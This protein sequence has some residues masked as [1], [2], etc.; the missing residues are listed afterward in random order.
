MKKYFIVLAVAALA[1]SAACTKV[2]TITPDQKISFEVANYVPQT[3]A[4]SSL[5]SEGY[6]SFTANA[7]FFQGE[8]NKMQYMNNETVSKG[9]DSWAPANDYYWPK[10]ASSYINFY[11]YAGSKAPAISADETMKTITVSYANVEIANNDNFMVAD[12]ALHFKSNVDQVEINDEQGEFNYTGENA[13]KH[14]YTGSSQSYTGVPTLFHH[15]LAKVAVVVKLKTTEAKKSANTTWTV[16]VLADGSNIKPI[17]KGSLT[18]KNTDAATAATIDSWK[19]YNGETEITD[20]AAKSI[21]W[22]AGTDIETIA[23]TEQTLTIPA[24]ATESADTKNLVDVRTVLPQATSGVNFNLK[25]EVSAS[26][27][28]TAFMKEIITLDEQTLAA[29]AS[30]VT[31]W[32]MNQITLYTITIDPV[33]EKVTFDPAVVEWDSVTGTITVPA[34]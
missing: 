31:A 17:K 1:A 6:T 25:Y 26:H 28:D 13:G 9:T 8:N 29:A 19:I 32:N 12:P 20:A 3:K 2:E 7:W 24:N 21:G 10:D 34:V 30:T 4:N 11:S 33:T 23:F 14:T 18:L 15:M 22:I 5:D 27:G 16:K